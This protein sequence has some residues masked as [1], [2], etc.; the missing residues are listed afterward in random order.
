MKERD[1]MRQ[2]RR[3]WGH[4][5]KITPKGK[6]KFKNLCDAGQTMIERTGLYTKH[7]VK[8]GKKRNFSWKSALDYLL[9]FHGACR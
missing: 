9:K 4:K 7:E 8:L 3:M 2:K 5:N 1:N 6:G